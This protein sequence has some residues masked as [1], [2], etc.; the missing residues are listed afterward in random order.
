ME[1]FKELSAEEA[2]NRPKLKLLPRT[3]NAPINDVA[4]VTSRSTIFGD[5]KPRDEK[6]Y[7]ER[8]RKESESKDSE[9]SSKVRNQK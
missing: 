8:R 5:A 9:I 6:E 3:V 4:N 1:E 2:A 7:V